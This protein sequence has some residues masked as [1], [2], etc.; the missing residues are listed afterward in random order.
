MYVL[1]TAVEQSEKSVHFNIKMH[2]AQ[3]GQSP[4]KL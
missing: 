1:N 2:K 3:T 4:L